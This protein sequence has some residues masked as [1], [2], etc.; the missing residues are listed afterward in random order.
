[1]A[2]SETPKFVYL[3]NALEGSAHSENPF[4]AGYAGHRTKVL[5]YVANLERELHLKDQKIAELEKERDEAL[6]THP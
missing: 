5:D 3:L 6:R 1:M 4:I 2:E